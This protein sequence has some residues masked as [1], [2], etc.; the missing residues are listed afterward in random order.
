MKELFLN[1][2]AMLFLTIGSYLVGLYCKTKSGFS[3]LHPFIICIPIIIVTL[4]I[5]GISY[6]EYME[7]NKIITFLLGPCVVS[8][9]L[10]LYDNLNVIKKNALAILSSIIVG[11]IAGVGSVYLLCK[12]MNLDELFAQSLVS[13]SVTTPIAMDL[14]E[15]LR[16]NISLTAVSVVLCGF[17]GAVIGPVLW[18]VFRFRHPV[19]RGLAMGC[20]SHGLGTARA[21]EM[22]AVEGA[23]SGLSIALMGIATALIIP[24]YSYLTT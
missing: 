19:A 10:S 14:T 6:T 16:G 5:T 3:L 24:L 22:G 11:S 4:Q 13:K 7:C 21:I 15:S 8:L 17:I 1:T 12:W 2:P 20:A 18:K 9:G 23:I